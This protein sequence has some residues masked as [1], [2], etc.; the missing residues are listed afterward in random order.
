MRSIIIFLFS[1]LLLVS[2]KFSNTPKYLD[3]T[4]FVK[5]KDTNGNP[6]EN[7]G[8]HF[9]VS[10]EKTAKVLDA[11]TKIQG[12]ERINLVPGGYELY[13]NYP[14][15]FT[16]QT[17]IMFALPKQGFVSLRITER[18]DST[19]VIRTLVDKQLQAGMYG[20]V[21]DGTNDDGR[22]VTNNVYACHLSA[23]WFHDARELFLNRVDPMR[24]KSL[25]CVPL[26]VSDADGIIE[27][28]QSI[29]PVNLSFPL[30]DETG[31]E[32]GTAE[33]PNVLQLIVLK[34]GYLPAV[35]EIDLNKTA[36]FTVVLEKEE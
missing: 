32:L 26:S 8:L 5:V 34:D 28:P 15:P 10:F 3:S 30:L 11:G 20:M 6:V 22:N 25:N 2:C 14:N 21:W 13:Q 35:K 9:Y 4:V 19:K 27:V 36:G 18:L 16:P 17:V 12:I 23:D 1:I 31:N 33:I 7:A 24:L 29:F